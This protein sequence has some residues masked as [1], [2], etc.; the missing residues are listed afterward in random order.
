MKYLVLFINRALSVIQLSNEFPLV[1][2]NYIRSTVE[3]CN[4]YY[5]QA[6]KKILSE[7]SISKIKTPRSRKSF[8]TIPEPEFFDELNFVKNQLGKNIPRKQPC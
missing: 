4:G 1:H 8:P 2:M 5:S 7:K 6:R 3:Q